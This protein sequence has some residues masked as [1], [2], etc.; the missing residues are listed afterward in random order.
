MTDWNLLTVPRGA[1]SFY[2]GT[3]L[4]VLIAIGLVPNGPL[5]G[6]V[7][8]T[9]AL[10]LVTAVVQTELSLPVERKRVRFATV[11]TINMTSVWIFA[12]ALLLPPVVEALVAVAVSSHLYVR[13]WRRKPLYQAVFAAFSAIASALAV[14]LAVVPTGLPTASVPA[15]VL[16]AVTYAVVGNVLML[17]SLKAHQLTTSWSD[18]LLE[19]ASLSLGGITA[20]MVA[21]RPFLIVMAILPVV[22]LHRLVL[23]RQL[24]ERATTD[25]KTGL[26]TDAEWRDRA[27]SELRR[28]RR[29]DDVFSVLMIDLD[30]FRRINSKY[31]HMGGDAAL[32]AVADAVRGEVRTYDSVG[33]FGGEEFVVLLPG[34]PQLHSM[35]VAERIRERVAELVVTSPVDAAVITGLSVSIGVAAYPEAGTAMERLLNRADRALYRAKG[36][37]RNQVVAEVG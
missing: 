25:H 20:V 17:G 31:G 13:A 35:A 14:H 29:R 2:L 3:E 30:H 6:E 12:G 36:F 5:T 37:G 24:E 15:I 28:A 18:T 4:V 34:S 33:R 32:R 23:M 9:V 22:V 10:L 1:V 27:A 11:P 21:T 19:F 8:Q 26:L 7:W 16:G